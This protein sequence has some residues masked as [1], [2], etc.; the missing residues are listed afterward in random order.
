ML[1]EYVQDLVNHLRSTNSEIEYSLETGTK[2]YRVIQNKN[3]EFP[4]LH[5]LICMKTGHVFRPTSWRA[6]DYTVRFNLMNETSRAECMRLA[7]YTGNY[8]KTNICPDELK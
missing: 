5:V 4:I 7:D 3:S 6:M 2:Y 1:S 8:L